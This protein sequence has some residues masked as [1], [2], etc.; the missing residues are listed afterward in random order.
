[1]KFLKK[2]IYSETKYDWQNKIQPLIQN[3]KNQ[4]DYGLV[5]IMTRT[6]TGKSFIAPKG[7]LND[8]EKYKKTF[9]Y[10]PNNQK[11]LIIEHENALE[12][13]CKN[14]SIEYV[15]N[16]KIKSQNGK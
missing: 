8:S 12:T 15:K 1:M 2:V 11:N 6:G 10:V 4:F 14:E 16:E 3:E 7:I 13:F 9:V 5:T